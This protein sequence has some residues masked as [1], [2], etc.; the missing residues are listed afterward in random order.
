MF[1]VRNSVQSDVQS[2][3]GFDDERIR[4]HSKPADIMEDKVL[5]T[6]YRVRLLETKREG[7][8]TIKRVSRLSGHGQFA[9]GS[10]ETLG[11]CKLLAIKDS[12]ADS[13]SSESTSSSSSSRHKKKKSKKDKKDKKPKKGKKNKKDKKSKHEDED[14][15]GHTVLHPTCVSASGFAAISPGC[16]SDSSMRHSQLTVNG[17]RWP[18]I[19]SS[20]LT[21]SMSDP[22]HASG[23]A[24]IDQGGRLVKIASSRRHRRRKRH[25]LLRKQRT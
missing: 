17:S 21:I 1:C 10:T 19:W 11:D 4:L 5:G 22:T 3:S 24:T 15:F 14:Y 8:R 20:G 9:A 16:V 12:T 18:S 2:A 6:V 23:F 25:A 13:S 7:R